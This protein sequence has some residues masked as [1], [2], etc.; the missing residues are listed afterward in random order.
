MHDPTK[1][2]SV[3]MLKPLYGVVGVNPSFGWYQNIDLIRVGQRFILSKRM[4]CSYGCIRTCRHD[5]R[6][7]VGH[8]FG[9]RV[10]LHY[11]YWFEGL[12]KA[13]IASRAT[14]STKS[15]P[16]M[17]PF[18][19]CRSMAALGFAHSPERIQCSIP[20]RRRN[21]RGLTRRQPLCISPLSQELVWID[22]ETEFKSHVCLT[23]RG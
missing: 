4:I 22:S 9:Y 13:N 2:R 18:L 10:A 12:K 8:A 5:F 14:P 23:P 1:I 7:V 11:W 16:L 17:S 20:R 15:M 21:K 3:G 19:P 6:N